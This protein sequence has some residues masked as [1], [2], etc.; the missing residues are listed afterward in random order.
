VSGNGRRWG[1]NRLD[2]QWARRV[3]DAAEVRPGEL[4]VDLCAGTGALTAPLVAAGAR[5]IAVEL[6]PRRAAQLRSRFADREVRVLELDALAF[7]PPRRP[8][9]V[10][11]SP[12]Y[13]ITTPLLRH[14]FARGTGLVAA[15][16]VLQRAAVDRFTGGRVAAARRWERAFAL[17]G[18]LRLP[19]AAFR[20]QPTVDSAVLVARRR[21][22][23]RR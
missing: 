1:W 5:V 21:R 6:H 18:G 17:E 15:D 14:L 3:V 10:V 12:A 11:A 20:P 13:A 9:R 23:L 19:R 2:P 16:L 4:V 8:F 22:S 7:R